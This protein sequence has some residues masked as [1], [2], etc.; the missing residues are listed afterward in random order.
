M[1]DLGLGIDTKFIICLSIQG[2]YLMSLVFVRPF[3]ETKNN[4]NKCICE[5]A[6]LLLL[7]LM[8]MYK[9]SDSWKGSTHNVFL[10]TI[11]ASVVLP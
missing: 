1:A 3:T 10:L 7:S 2:L 5:C 11:A 4:I 6:V 9:N 8:Y